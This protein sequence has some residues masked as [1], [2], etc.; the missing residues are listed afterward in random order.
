[1]AAQEEAKAAAT[2]R[3]RRG[4]PLLRGCRR[5]RY[6][7]GLHPAQMEALRAMCGALIPSL[8][9]TERLHGDSDDGG[10]KDLERFYL[11]SAAD[12]TIPEEVAELVTRCV[13]EAV[14][15]VNVVLWILSTKVGTLALCGRLCISGKFPYVR[16]FADIPVERR[17]E[18]L[19]QWSKARCLFPLKI[20][21][22]IIKIL[23]HYAF[24][25]TVCSA[26]LVP[27]IFCLVYIIMLEKV[28]I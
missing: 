10:R 28:C 11:A 16:K 9:V 18:A 1:M 25:T 17:E 27:C 4:H 6:T 15:L 12:G 2:R 3:R 19:S 22:V 24:F 5:E 14:V 21:F 26:C 13:W 20:T 7:H 23:S 8:P